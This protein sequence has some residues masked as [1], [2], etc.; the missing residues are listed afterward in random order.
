[1]SRAEIERHLLRN[2]AELHRRPQAQI[3]KREIAACLA[4]VAER[5]GAVQA[6]RTRASLLAFFAWGCRRGLL[7]NKP[8]AFTE[9]HKEESRH[10]VLSD[11]ELRQL[12]HAL[13]NNDYGR[14]ARLLILTGQRRQEIGA[15]RWS[16]VDFPRGVIS[17]PGER[18]KNA[19]PHH[20]P[21]S[22]P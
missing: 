12:W 13:P 18:T 20:V 14:V 15:L 4:R 5:S 8:T 10:R 22:P 1:R 19:R 21:L 16:E 3:G 11:S 7:A 9:T 2:A 6:N 17:L